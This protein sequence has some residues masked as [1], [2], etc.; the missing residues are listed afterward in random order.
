MISLF[1]NIRQFNQT[2][3]TPT[4]APDKAWSYFNL[5][6]LREIKDSYLTYAK[7][8]EI[9]DIQSLKTICDRENVISENGKLG[10]IE[11]Y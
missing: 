3:F 4:I 11:I 5:Y 6:Y 9:N 1:E 10:L 7:H 8:P 2:E